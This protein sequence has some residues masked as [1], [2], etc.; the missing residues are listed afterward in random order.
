MTCSS[1]A[2]RGGS[3]AASPLGPHLGVSSRLGRCW[4]PVSRRCTRQQPGCRLTAAATHVGAR[5]VAA[6]RCLIS[7]GSPSPGSGHGQPGGYRSRT[8][9]RS[10]TSN[11]VA[12]HEAGHETASGL[13]SGDAKS[14]VW[15]SQLPASLR[16]RCTGEGSRAGRTSWIVGASPARPG[17]SGKRFVLRRKVLKPRSLAAVRRG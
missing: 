5:V 4:P 11:R 7:C 16:S 15:V 3:R 12:A 6:R 1:H 13:S 17:C 8:V 9:R 10:P 2:R 14:P